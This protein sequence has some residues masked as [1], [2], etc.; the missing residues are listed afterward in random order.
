MTDLQEQTETTTAATETAPATE[1]QSQAAATQAETKTPAATEQPK[2]NGKAPATLVAGADPAAEDE[3]KETAKAAEKATQIDRNEL[4][5]ELRKM[6]A[7]HYAA[8]DKKAEAK[9]L[10]RLERVKD[11]KS[12]WGMYR[13]LESR[14]TGGGLVK[15][16]G[17]DAKPE[18]IAE[19]HKALGVPEKPEE[20]FKSIKLD[21]GA[22]IG[23]ADKPV[24]DSFAAAVHKAG[25]PPAV[26]NAAMNW[27]FQQQE[28]AA[29]A[30]DEA[31]DTFRRES[32]QALKDEWGP[33]YKRKLNSIATVFA[34][35]PG[36]ADV[37]NPNSLW[38]QVATARTPDGKLLGNH[39]D[40]IKL[41]TYVAGEINPE[42]T[43]VD[44]GNQAGMGLEA[45]L[46]SI[47]A[48]RKTD[49]KKYWSDAIQA[50]EAELIAAKQK[51]QARQG[52]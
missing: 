52:A 4:N 44:D 11:I 6:I 36:G 18:E 8:G 12:L 21:N 24:A 20:Y 26:V 32:L 30:L 28:Q 27:Y 40:W 7:E 43:V 50:R 46:A 13:E 34:T 10:K 31:D 35:A 23:E 3:A 38:S 48:L 51:I 16:P 19:Y 9:E 39:P 47:Q 14:F 15:M 49:S 17:K 25:A 41:M 37:N 1:T 45:E 42:A 2:S 22:V 33:A 5:E 29:A